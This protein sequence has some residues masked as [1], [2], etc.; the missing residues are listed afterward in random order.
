MPHSGV[1][2]V[3]ADECAGITGESTNSDTALISLTV[4]STSFN[5]LVKIF[6]VVNFAIQLYEEAATLYEKAQYWNKAA[7]VY[8]K[9]K[10]WYDI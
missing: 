4:I 6:T 7:A 2:S 3:K 9:S 5:I 10:N 8:I 1:L